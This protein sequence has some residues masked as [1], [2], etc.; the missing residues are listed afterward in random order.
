MG[1][2]PA[3]PSGPHEQGPFCFQSNSDQGVRGED[4]A[5]EEQ[6]EGGA[7]KSDS[8]ETPTQGNSHHLV[9]KVPGCGWGRR[10]QKPR[11][12]EERGCTDREGMTGGGLKIKVEQKYPSDILTLIEMKGAQKQKQKSKNVHQSPNVSCF[13][14]KSPMISKK[15]KLFC[16]WPQAQ[17][18]NLHI[19][20][21]LR[22][23]PAHHQGT[24]CGRAT[25]RVCSS[26]IS[27]EA[28]PG[29][30]QGTTS[31]SPSCCLQPRGSSLYYLPTSLS[32]SLL[33]S[34]LLHC[35]KCQ[36]AGS[37]MEKIQRS[38]YL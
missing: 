24:G 4:R 16:A 11:G 36:Y 19:W 2:T 37:K 23:Q 32:H 34:I 1:A 8:M 7:G 13:S 35:C 33:K 31:C 20:P 3:V 29:A 22:E 10:Q 6:Q 21:V 27:R 28:W 30:L 17:P 9:S 25:P 14:N 12:R 26:R 38:P 18:Q 5:G 15:S